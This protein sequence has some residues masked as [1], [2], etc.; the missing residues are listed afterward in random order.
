MERE[1]SSIEMNCSF[2]YV[3]FC[4]WSRIS[5]SY[6]KSWWTITLQQYEILLSVPDFDPV[7]IS[8]YCKDKLVNFYKSLT[9]LW[10]TYLTKIIR[11]NWSIFIDLVSFFFRSKK[12]SFIIC[13]FDWTF[14]MKF[15]PCLW[16]DSI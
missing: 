13:R 14:S 11:Q 4:F 10:F 2:F 6:E 9:P 5:I 3:L 12:F 1:M 16:F 8:L 15:S 7:R